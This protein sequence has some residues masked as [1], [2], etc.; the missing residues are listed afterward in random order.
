[1]PAPGPVS[2]ATRPERLANPP[3]EQTVGRAAIH[4]FWAEALS[5][6]PQFEPSRRRRR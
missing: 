1:M 4:K 5:H 6:M 3:G 2:R